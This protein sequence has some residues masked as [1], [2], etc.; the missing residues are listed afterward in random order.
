MLIYFAGPL[1]NDAEKWFNERLT[2]KLEQLGFNVF[3]PQRDGF[4]LNDPKARFEPKERADYIFKLDRDKV[5]ES[6]ILL[7][8]LDGR[9]PDEG[10]AFELGLAYAQ[11]TLLAKPYT[12][13]GY[14][15]D[16]RVA[17][18]DRPVNAMLAGALEHI[19]TEEADLLDYLKGLL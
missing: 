3:L 4:E 17:F 11:K 16:R 19:F 8:V 15:T 14:M 9:V 13:I 18:L 2:E 6:D 12:L 5:F 10:A 7:Y 1:F